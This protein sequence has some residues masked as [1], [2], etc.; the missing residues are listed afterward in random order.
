MGPPPKKSMYFLRREKIFISRITITQHPSILRG[1]CS[2]KDQWI[3]E[4][5]SGGRGLVGMVGQGVWMYKK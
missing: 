4:T 2:K 5:E 1:I 3:S